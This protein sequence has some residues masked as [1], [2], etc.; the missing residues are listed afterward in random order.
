MISRASDKRRKIEAE[1]R[2][3]QAGPCPAQDTP[4]VI[5]DEPEPE[6]VFKKDISADDVFRDFD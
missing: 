4:V 3:A 5:E 6:D 1:K 2:R